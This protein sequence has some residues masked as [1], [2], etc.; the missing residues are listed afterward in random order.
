MDE[1]RESFEGKLE[2][3]AGN[4]IYLE[5]VA[6]IYRKNADHEKAAEAYKALSK[7]DPSNVR[8]FYY[9]AAALNNSEKKE[10]AEDM[11]NR[12]SE[13][14]VSNNRS[15]DMRFLSALGTI[16]YRA[17]MHTHALKLLKEALANVDHRHGGGGW[18]EEGLYEMIGKSAFATKQ[19]EEAAE[20]YQQLKK[21]ARSNSK[22]DAADKAIKRAFQEGKLY[23]KQIPEQEKKV[24]ENPD[25]VDARVALAQNYELSEKLDDAVT[26]YQ[27]ISKLEP[28]EARWQ[29]KIGELYTNST[30]SNKQERLAKAAAA[31]QKA[32]LIEP[33]SYELYTLLAKTH[34][35]QDDISKA[36]EVYRQALQVSLKPSEHDSAVKAILALYDSKE[37]AEK[38]LAILKE[39]G[40]KTENS[41]FLQKSLGDTYA[42]SGD[43]EKAAVAYRKWLEI[44]KS[45]TNQRN[46]AREIH[47]LAEELLRKDILP[48]VALELAKQAVQ[49]R[50][51]SANFST[52]GQAYLVNGEYDKALKQFQVSFNLMHQSEGFHSSTFARLLTRIAEAGK[53]VEDK[54]NY[55]EM[56]NKLVE[57]FSIKVDKDLNISLSLA[58]LYHEIGSTEN[59]TKVVLG[60]GF[61][62]ETT[63]LTLGPFDNTKGVG[64]NTAYITEETSMIDATAK[65][66]GVSGQISWQKASDDTLDGFFAFGNEENPFVAYAWITFTSPEERKAQI[67]FD[68]DDQGKI[69]L[70]SK[71]VY[72]HR[73]TRGA[74]IDRRTIPITLLAGKNSILVKVCNESLPWGFYLRI[75]DTDGRPYDDLKIVD[76][77]G[78]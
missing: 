49:S 11:L 12:G 77:G 66:D 30:Q 71:K 72:A 42:E 45:N 56:M 50:K 67:R 37:N 40:P 28:D 35:Q 74:K 33:T 17:E 15:H 62:P 69:W 54:A 29:K 63:W 14:L 73:R 44:H 24:A 36:E 18:H 48:D 22:K 34:K 9:A 70:N 39:L 27:M 51:T 55:I 41:P 2:N 52:L 4:P 43:L 65:Y 78:N 76:Q 64:Y 68:S 60:T 23:E 3:D 59:A 26:Q 38:R 7:A 8:S 21:I 16:C 31:Y 61:F 1:L 58:K 32:I 25:N 47:V 5:I 53:I 75:T 13:A 20:A 57:S 46:Q 6:E 10:L 19:Y